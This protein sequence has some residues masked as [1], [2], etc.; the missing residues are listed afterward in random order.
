[1]VFNSTF[2]IV[3]V[4][5]KY[6]RNLVRGVASLPVDSVPKPMENLGCGALGYYLIYQG[7]VDIIRTKPRH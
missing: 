3:E 5:E 1:M 6:I 4:R 2:H 7:Q